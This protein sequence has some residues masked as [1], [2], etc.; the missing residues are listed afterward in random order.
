MSAQPVSSIPPSQP[1]RGRGQT[2][3]PGEPAPATSRPKLRRRPLLIAAALVLMA[4]GALTAA[5][6]TTVVGHTVQVVALRDTVQRGTQ[7]TRDNLMTVNI[8]P[9]PALKTIPAS[10]LDSV[11][12]QYASMDL[13]GGGI[14]PAGAY[15]PNNALPSG[16]ALVGVSLTP[17][18][19]PS[20]GLKPGDRV[21]IVVTPRSQDDPPTTPPATIAATVVASHPVG[22]QG[23]VVVDVAVPQGQSALL[24]ATAAT[25]RVAV[26]LNGAGS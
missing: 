26:V 20:Q 24:A 13:P 4:V 10:Q 7:I 9:D 25:G 3:T 2:S 1:R 5:W 23:Q 17:A 22:D 19:A 15:S 21:N 8:S 18:Q 11:V 6:L 14:L 16:Q 12:G